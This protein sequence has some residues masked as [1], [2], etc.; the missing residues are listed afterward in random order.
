MPAMEPTAASESLANAPK[1]FEPEDLD[2]PE[3]EAADQPGLPMKKSK[4]KGKG[5]KSATRRGD[6]SLSASRGTGFEGKVSLTCPR[7]W[8]ELT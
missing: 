5:T 4:R 6:G 1:N 3:A 2:A 7:N 8:S